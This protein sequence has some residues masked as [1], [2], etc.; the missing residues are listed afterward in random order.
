MPKEEKTEEKTSYEKTLDALLNQEPASLDFSSLQEVDSYTALNG[1]SAKV[2]WLKSR[3]NGFS[4]VQKEKKVDNMLT[5]GTIINAVLLTGINTDLPGTII[6]VVSQNVYDSFTKQNILIP[7]GSKLIASY[8]SS[9]SWGQTRILV[10]WNQ[11]ILENGTIINLNGYQGTDGLGRAG[12]TGR[13]DNHLGSIIGGSLLS[14]LISIGTGYAGSIMED[15]GW[16]SLINSLASS[17]GSSVQSVSENLLNKIVDRQPTI[18]VDAGTKIT[19]L[20]ND[21]ITLPIYEE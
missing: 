5:N 7:K 11:L 14:S 6:A 3:Q 2:D 8:D 4:I 12:L 21:N 1:Q 13:V 17:T 16:G 9:I 15:K 20:S 18:S 10:S 19:I